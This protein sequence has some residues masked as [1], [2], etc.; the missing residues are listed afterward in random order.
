MRLVIVSLSYPYSSKTSLVYL[1]CKPEELFSQLSL[2]TVNITLK[3]IKVS[4]LSLSSKF[5]RINLNSLKSFNLTR[6]LST[7]LNIIKTHKN[8]YQPQP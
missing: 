3:S 1:S 7:N 4:Y 6:T 8:T 5:I 2:K